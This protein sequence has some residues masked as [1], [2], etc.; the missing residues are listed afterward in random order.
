MLGWVW[1][2]GS[3]VA[4]APWQQCLLVSL[5]T[6]VPSSEVPCVVGVR[7]GGWCCTVWRGDGVLCH[8]VVV[9]GCCC[10]WIRWQCSSRKVF[11]PGDWAQAPVAWR[12]TT[13][14]ADRSTSPISKVFCKAFP[15]AA[16]IR[17]EVTESESCG[18]AR[19][20]ETGIARES[21]R[22][23]ESV[24]AHERVRGSGSLES[25]R[26]ESNASTHAIMR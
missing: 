26:S 18:R 20:G 1:I 21:K 24:V 14:R 19:E 11:L 23:R 7:G 2:Q 5:V 22:A 13:K 25:T 3:C 8:V 12:R 9:G 15:V 17:T 6:G 10:H 4:A 16:K